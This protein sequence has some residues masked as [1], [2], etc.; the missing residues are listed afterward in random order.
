MF[1]RDDPNIVYRMAR[2]PN[3]AAAVCG[4][5]GTL[6]VLA[7]LDGA[8]LWN[9]L[10]GP[11][12]TCDETIYVADAKIYVY[13]LQ[14]LARK[15]WKSP[16]E[17]FFDRNWV[18]QT[19]GGTRDHP[20]LGRWLLGWAHWLTDPNPGDVESFNVIR[21][22][23]AP[24]VAYG[25]LIFLIGTVAGHLA[26]PGAGW[27]AAISALL[28]PRLFAH[29]HIAAL[30]TFV[31]VFYCAALA[32]AAWAMQRQKRS[33][34]SFSAAGGGVHR[35][36]D[37]QPLFRWGVA[38]VLTG[39]ALLTKVNG[40]L[41]PVLIVPWALWYL[42]RRALA[43]LATWGAAAL[44][45]F[46][47]G[48]P[49]LWPWL[50]DDPATAWQHLVSFLS[51]A[52]NRQ[53]IPVWYFGESIADKN[54]PF[55]YPW[56]LFG[57][58]VPLGLHALGLVGVHR[59]RSE[60][61][62]NPAWSLFAAGGL[63][64]LVLFSIPGVVVYDG[65]RLFL[66]VLPL[67]ALFIGVG[68]VTLL[69]WLRSR[70]T[71]LGAPG[72]VAPVLLAVL[73]GDQALGTLRMHPYQLSYYNVLAGGLRGADR[74]GLEATYWGDS[75]GRDVLARLPAHSQVV[76]APNLQP[77]Q[78]DALKRS[79]PVYDAKN[80]DLTAELTPDL[81]GKRGDERKHEPRYLL[82]YNRR[83]YLK[84][85][86]PLLEPQNIVYAERRQGVWLAAIYR[87]P[88]H[89]TRLT[90]RSSQRETNR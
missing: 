78:V 41:L 9:T 71:A 20:P 14:D 76:Y 5:I 88:D 66:M 44:V 32:G 51:T 87:L 73:L 12:V 90:S 80:I 16:L 31:A 34:Q 8:G 74:L 77:R 60:L 85:E 55:H 63:V 40:L 2:H 64:M 48:W 18:E 52:T 61:W 23:V 43:P 58:T 86:L 15:R 89:A 49:W 3:F 70:L 27:L 79:C 45:T 11:G 29:A 69:R 21:A 22:R 10:P 35:K 26:G 6:A 57:L 68:G 24:A 25:L 47:L 84:E 46:V 42:R 67:W 37:S 50:W 65:V 1:S 30:D 72:L 13:V 17:L 82:V 81:T 54:L 19:Y 75:V 33:R 53:I 56:V 62:R 7:T 39:L 59:L 28:M 38:G 83:A 4:L 36:K